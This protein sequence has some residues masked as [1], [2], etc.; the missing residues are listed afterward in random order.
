MVAFKS[1]PNP[2]L[3]AFFIEYMNNAKNQTT[4]VTV[5]GNLP[6]RVDLTS[7]HLKYPSRQADMDVFLADLVRTP[8]ERS[9]ANSDPAFSGSGTALIAEM[10]KVVA[11]KKKLPAAIADLQKTIESLLKE[12][13][14]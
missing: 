13:N 10:D 5:G 6:T 2:A 7:G 9:Y 4:F 1:S 14:P 3:S 12:L 8:K 11:G